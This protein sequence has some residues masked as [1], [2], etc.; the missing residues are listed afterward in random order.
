[1][2]AGA[3]IQGGEPASGRSRTGEAPQARGA[4]GDDDAQVAPAVGEEQ[5]Q[6]SGAP[7]HVQAVP[8]RERRG[9]VG[10]ETRD[11]GL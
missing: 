3:G 9:P 4:H 6:H 5:D 1:M 11:G 7:A 8:R 10:A 2:G